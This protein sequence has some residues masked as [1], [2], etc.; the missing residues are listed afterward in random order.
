MPQ[1]VTNFY[2]QLNQHEIKEDVVDV[3]YLDFQKALLNYEI[4]CNLNVV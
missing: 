3:T 1:K 2:E 4:H